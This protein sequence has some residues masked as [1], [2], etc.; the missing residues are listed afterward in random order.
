MRE[1]LVTL[2]EFSTVL[3]SIIEMRYYI[4]EKPLELK[5]REDK[6]AQMAKQVTTLN[7]DIE[8]LTKQLGIIDVDLAESRMQYKKYEHQQMQIRRTKEFEA[9]NAEI[10]AVKQKIDDLQK[11]RKDLDARIETKR[12]D[13]I[14]ISPKYEQEKESIEQERADLMVKIDEMKPQYDEMQKKKMALANMLPAD[15]RV[16]VLSMEKNS[17]YKN[18]IMANVN[19]NMCGGCKVSLPSQLIADVRRAITIK[20]CPYCGRLLFWEE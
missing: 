19:K 15:I 13:L 1:V 4:E 3:S 9:L 11:E 7:N 2:K 20:K 17:R 6:L 18:G 5:P 12:N 10:Y 16:S 14:N 8:S